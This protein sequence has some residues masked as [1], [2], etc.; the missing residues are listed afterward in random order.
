LTAATSSKGKERLVNEGLSK[1]A[2]ELQRTLDRLTPSQRDGLITGLEVLTK[3]M[4][5]ER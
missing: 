3:E 2:A 4:S 5:R 1:R